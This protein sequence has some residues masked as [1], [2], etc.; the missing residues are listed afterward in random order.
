MS[1]WTPRSTDRSPQDAERE[2]RGLL[3]E[4]AR[5]AADPLTLPLTADLFRVGL[6]S[7]ATV[8]LMLALEDAFGFEFQDELLTHASFQ[9]I[10]A[11]LATVSAHGRD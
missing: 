10:A 7:H 9:S 5:L 8:T 2:V 6:T 4:H 1:E 3:A 11:I